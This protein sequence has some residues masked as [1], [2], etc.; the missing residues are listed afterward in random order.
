MP[1]SR[2]KLIFFEKLI[3]MPLAILAITDGGCR[4]GRR[5]ADRLPA[6]DL[7][8]CRGRVRAEIARCWQEYEALVCIM[9][10][11]IV[12]RSIAPLLRDKRKDPAV[13][14]CDEAG[15]FVIPLVSGH[16]GGGNALARR[17]AGLTGASPVITTA[18]DVLGRTAL[19]LWARDLGLRIEDKKG[20]T[21]AMGRLVDRGSVTVYSDPPLPVLP[22]DIRPVADPAAADL[23]ITWRTT[24]QAGRGAILRPPVLVA[25]IGCNRGT[26]A[27]EIGAA[28]REACRE[29]GLAPASLC[30]LASLDLKQDETGLLAYAADRGLPIDFYHRDLLNRV[31][32]VSSSEAVFRATGARGVAEPAALLSAGTDQLL[33]RKM[34]WKNVTVAIAE[35]ASPWS[36]PG[37][38][39]STW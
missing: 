11:G 37:R 27:D 19:D 23:V 5:L 39:L 17:I 33:V 3:V 7:V 31:G 32:G 22:P 12:V 25:G 30:R 24:L 20:M 4:L 18:S 9:A 14:V 6:A 16:L 15:D 38:A 29:H 1:L 36:E 13:L 26:G 2:G 35:V 28:V 8:P 10:T 21:R 34:K